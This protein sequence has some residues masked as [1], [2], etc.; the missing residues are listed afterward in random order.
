M[1]NHTPDLKRLEAIRDAAAKE[2]FYIHHL[3]SDN[4]D[5]AR[6][7]IT[8]RAYHKALLDFGNACAAHPDPTPAKRHENNFS[9]KLQPKGRT[10]RIDRRQ[11]CTDESNYRNYRAFKRNHKD[12]YPGRFSER[13][14]GYEI[15][16]TSNPYIDEPSFLVSE[17]EICASAG[18]KQRSPPRGA[19]RDG[20]T[21]PSAGHCKHCHPARQPKRGNLTNP[22]PPLELPPNPPPKDT[23]AK[24]SKALPPTPTSAASPKPHGLLRHA[25][26]AQALREFQAQSHV[27]E[28]DVAKV[29]RHVPSLQLSF[30]QPHSSQASLLSLSPHSPHS[31]HSSHSPHSIQPSR[32]PTPQP[33]CSTTP[34]PHPSPT[35]QPTSHHSSHHESSPHQHPLRSH[36]PQPLRPSR[37]IRSPNRE[38]QVHSPPP[39]HHLHRSPTTHHQSHH[40]EPAPHRS[41]TPAPY[42]HHHAPTPPI[43]HH[44]HAPTP[45]ISHHSAQRHHTLMHRASQAML[46]HGHNTQRV[47]SREA[48]SMMQGMNLGGGRLVVRLSGDGGGGERGR[49]DERRDFVGGWI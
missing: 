42:Y 39:Q 14:L 4:P 49:R 47:A 21:Y 33:H 41:T 27:S 9:H 13:K 22:L 31:H 5:D 24:L 8:K 11:R 25:S 35:P 28:H 20:C 18:E 2:Y 15:A 12:Y 3:T 1:P 26:S 46:N 30:L 37:S 48:E 40:Y 17:A 16:N 43:S 10:V 29:L 45:P 19:C 34:Q 38:V 7:G 44:H 32:S 6:R 23:R 36:T